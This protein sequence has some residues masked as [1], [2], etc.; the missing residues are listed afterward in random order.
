MHSLR[1]KKKNNE[2]K[3]KRKKSL[4]SQI[5][6]KK[7]AIVMAYSGRESNY[8]CTTFLPSRCPQS[9]GEYLYLHDTIA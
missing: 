9:T 4:Q 2:K 5:Q 7:K 1:K 6:G 3:R 8:L